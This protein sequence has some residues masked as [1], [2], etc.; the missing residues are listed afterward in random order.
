MPNCILFWLYG[1]PPTVKNVLFLLKI[2]KQTMKMKIMAAAAAIVAICLHSC[3]DNGGSTIHENPFDNETSGSGIKM[4]H[5]HNADTVFLNWNITYNGDFDAISVMDA[6][7]K[8]NLKLPKTASECILT[9]FPYN[10]PVKTTLALTKA[11][12]TVSSETLFINI[13]GLDRT[14]KSKIIPDKGSVTAGDGMY[15]IGLPDGRSI[16][17]MGDSFIGDVVD[18]VL[19]GNKHMYRNSYSVYDPATGK[20]FAIV[21]ENE[22]SAAVPEGQP[23]ETKWYWPGHG[24]VD[25]D[26]LCIFQSL[27]YQGADGAWGFRYENTHLLQY[28]L[29]DI[30][31]LS[32]T[33]I[34]YTGPDNVHYGA[35]ALNDGEYLYIYAQIDVT[36]DLDPKT[37]VKVARAKRGNPGKDWEYWNG[38]SWTVDSNSAAK[39]AGLD[40]VAV[41]SQFNV[42]QIDGKYVLLTQ[43]KNWNSGEIYTFTS[44]KPTGPWGT[45]RL[46]YKIPVSTLDPNWFTYNAMGHPQIEKDGMILVTYDVNTA[47]DWWDNFHMESYRP[48]FF[49]IEK[50]VILG[51]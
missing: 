48:R 16:F 42:F 39:L 40:A 30:K 31:L 6:A 9:H 17:L 51:K 36:N 19:V 5:S 45:K 14:I 15:S 38:T 2:Q 26:R 23:N 3:G 24:F 37:E 12:K 35:A 33:L 41:S 4:N 13:D 32:D 44:D 18:G 1:I 29:P 8:N 34:P 11:G 27:M 7:G 10:Q 20:S 46:I 25:G 49:W 22:H 28:S 43:K 50:D 21:G 47:G